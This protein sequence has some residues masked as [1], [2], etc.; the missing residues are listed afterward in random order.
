MASLG[1]DEGSYFAFEMNRVLRLPQMKTAYFAAVLVIASCSTPVRAAS[2]GAWL[3][4][5]AKAGAACKKKA[6]L[7]QSRVIGG[8]PI[9]FSDRLLLIVEGTYPQLHMNNRKGKFYCLYNQETNTAE[10]SEAH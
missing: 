9:L 7:K 3:E 2:P 5:F 6:D 8:E 10:I 1:I 4:L